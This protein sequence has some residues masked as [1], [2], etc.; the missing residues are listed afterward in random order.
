[1]LSILFLS[2]A[3]TEPTGDP[4]SALAMQNKLIHEFFY[5]INA[6]FREEQ[7]RGDPNVCN[8][9][10]NIPV[11]VF[12]PNDIKFITSCLDSVIIAI[13]VSKMYDIGYFYPEFV[14]CT[15]QR[16]MLAWC[17]Q[18]FRIDTRSFPRDAQ[19]IS[20]EVNRIYGCPD[21]TVLPEGLV[22]LALRENRLSGSIAL[23]RLPSQMMNLYLDDNPLLLQDVVY[24][25]NV[26]KSMRRVVVDKGRV[27]R[28]TPVNGEDKSKAWLWY[29]AVR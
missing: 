1:M 22:T 15:V 16:F 17:N 25:G 26:P 2:S 29:E 4:H 19:R 10:S 7:S 28:F 21:L 13:E 6:P 24:F 23:T 27:K 11:G 18:K 3:D 12:Y 8:W 5:S 20:F 9:R 14:P